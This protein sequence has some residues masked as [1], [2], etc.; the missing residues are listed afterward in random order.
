VTKS[1]CR[2]SK[3]RASVISEMR[4]IKPTIF[5]DYGQ[6]GQLLIISINAM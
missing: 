2:W 6:A 4:S 5:S 3:V 1:L